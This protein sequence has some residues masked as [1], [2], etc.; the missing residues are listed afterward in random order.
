MI[1][2]FAQD[3]GERMNKRVGALSD[4]GTSIN[5]VTRLRPP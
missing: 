5:D 3:A 2:L 1:I 4:V